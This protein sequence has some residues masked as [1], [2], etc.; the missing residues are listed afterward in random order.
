MLR[1]LLRN[2]V[3]A[4]LH[5][6]PGAGLLRLPRFVAEYA[7]YRRR[8]PER[9]PLGDTYPCLADRTAHTPFDGHYFFQGAWLARR[10]AEARPQQHTDIGSSV[11]AISVLSGF[12]DTVFVDYRPLEVS[13]PGLT[14]EKGD[15]T[16]LPYRDD[17]LQ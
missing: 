5:P 4:M 9:V 14:C 2:W 15:I 8:S 3:L 11:M 6:V 13:L 16:A 7:R 1:T 10:L 12:V 17:T